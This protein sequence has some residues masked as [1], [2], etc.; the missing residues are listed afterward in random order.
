[1]SFWKRLVGTLA[2]C[3]C[4]VTGGA[5]ADP[6]QSASDD[7][8]TPY[9]TPLSPETKDD[10]RYIVTTLAHSSLFSLLGHKRDLQ[11]AGD[12]IRAHPLKFIAYMFSDEDLRQS[13][14]IMRKRSLIWR[15]FSEGFYRSLTDA[16][17]HGNMR[18][19]YIDDF[20][21]GLGINPDSVRPAIE[22]QR[23]DDLM[24]ILIATVPHKQ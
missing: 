6:V 24:D 17:N 19:E 5:Y 7:V 2:T 23:W 10:I 18:E 21:A 20:A 13:L 16:V 1:M 12:R 11:Y 14:T 4:F 22:A 3:V 9:E 8:Q 15:N